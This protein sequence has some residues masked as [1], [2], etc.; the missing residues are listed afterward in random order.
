MQ[1]LIVV[2]VNKAA[3]TDTETFITNES[4]EEEFTTATEFHGDVDFRC[5]SSLR[6][7]RNSFNYQS[8]S[9]IL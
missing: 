3:A 4:W 7:P 6:N 8:N 5:Q 9:F 2:T 1:P